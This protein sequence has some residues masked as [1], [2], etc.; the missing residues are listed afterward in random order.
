M[1]LTDGGLETD[2]IFHC[3]MELPLFA[4]FP[5]VDDPAGA[6]VLGDYYRRHTRVAEE[7]NVGFVLEAPTWRAS[8]FWGALLGYTSAQLDA[9]NRRAIGML[10]ELRA[11]LG[12]RAGPMVISGAIGPR[13]DGYNPEVLMDPEQAQGYHMTQLETLST[14]EADLATAMTLT[15]ADEAIGI[16]QAAAATGI[17]VVISFT[18]ETNGRLPDGSTLAE[19]I[20]TVDEATNSA[21]AYY[22]INCAHPTHFSLALDPAAAWARRIPDDQG[23]RLDHEPR[24]ARQRRPAR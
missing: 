24:R 17:P 12:E 10:S 19:A 7:A 2:L 9:V 22:G 20:A 6:E 11:E 13:S 15:Y 14:T 21:P 8:S 18:V 4:A 1:C 16:A 23:E 3:G 5:L